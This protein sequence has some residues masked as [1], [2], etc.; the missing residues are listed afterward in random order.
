MSIKFN[1]DLALIK[2]V[3]WAP[4]GELRFVTNSSSADLALRIRRGIQKAVAVRD[5][6]AN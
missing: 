6:E 3:T 2:T 1:C 4:I 5:P